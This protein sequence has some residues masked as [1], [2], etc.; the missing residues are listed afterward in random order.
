MFMLLFNNSSN[1]DNY[2]LITIYVSK[3]RNGSNLVIFELKS[4]TDDE[5]QLVKKNYKIGYM[6]NIIDE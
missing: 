6:L 3:K 4:F 1:K 5:I 2:N